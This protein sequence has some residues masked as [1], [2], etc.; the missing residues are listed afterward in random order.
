MQNND[1]KDVAEKFW[2]LVIVIGAL[3]YFT[4]RT[5]T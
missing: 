1:E 2:I 5:V 4:L 3:L